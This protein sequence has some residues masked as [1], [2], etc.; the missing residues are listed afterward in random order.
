[1]HSQYRTD[2]DRIPYGNVEDVDAAENN[3]YTTPQKTMG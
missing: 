1:M 2:E 3:E